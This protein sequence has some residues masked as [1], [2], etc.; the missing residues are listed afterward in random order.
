MKAGTVARSDRKTDPWGW[1]CLALAFR[2]TGHAFLTMIGTQR[3]MLMSPEQWRH[4]LKPRWAPIRL[5]Y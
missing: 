2:L 4:W 5:D 3:G 1:R